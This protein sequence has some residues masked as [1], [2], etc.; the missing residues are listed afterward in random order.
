MYLAVPTSLNEYRTRE[1][2]PYI[3]E[4][5]IRGVRVYFDVPNSPHG[6]MHRPVFLHVQT[7]PMFGGNARFESRPWIEEQRVELPIEE[8]ERVLQATAETIV[9]ESLQNTVTRINAR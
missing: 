1:V 8:F 2:Y 6:D 7:D 5:G 4:G 3:C 9:G